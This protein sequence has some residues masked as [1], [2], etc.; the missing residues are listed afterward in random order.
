MTKSTA[1]PTTNS[2]DP[3]APPPRDA[4]TQPAPDAG[5]AEG[6]TPMAANTMTAAEYA[7]TQHRLGVSMVEVARI[8]GVGERAVHRWADPTPNSPGPEATA[9]LRALIDERDEQLAAEVAK[10][11]A[12]KS[13][14]VVLERHATQPA[15]EAAGSPHASVGA[16]DAFLAE[17][18]M[19]LNRKHIEYVLVAAETED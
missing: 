6:A 15:L 1:L 9:K 16:Q 18:T 2:I 14:P 8:L 7:I 3:Q 17:L 4:V 5:P 11:S 13:P 10:L 12:R 19:A